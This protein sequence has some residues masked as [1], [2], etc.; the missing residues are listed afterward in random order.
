[1]WEVGFEKP[2]GWVIVFEVFLIIQEKIYGQ[3]P[4]VTFALRH[5]NSASEQKSRIQEFKEKRLVK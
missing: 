1:M 2:S 4:F 3:A 5:Y